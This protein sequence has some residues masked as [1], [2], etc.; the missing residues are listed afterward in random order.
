MHG[1]ATAVSLWVTVSIGIAA[2]YNLYG[3]AAVLSGT[4][5]LTLRLLKPFKHHVEE[6]MHEDPGRDESS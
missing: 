6:T 3:L 5:L 2:S 1:L 4:T